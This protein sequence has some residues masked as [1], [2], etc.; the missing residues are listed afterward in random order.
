MVSKPSNLA[1]LFPVHK[2]S[3][4]EID[5]HLANGQDYLQDAAQ[6]AVSRAGRYKA[7]YDA[8][9]AFALAAIK[10][11]GFRPKEGGHRQSLFAALAHALPA[12][13]RDQ[14]VFEQ[15]HKERNRSEYDGAPIDITDSKLQALVAAAANLQEETLSL[16]KTWQTAQ[17]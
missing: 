8:S 4:A 12:T 2:A 9:H 10:M 13:E 17:N 16:Y 1:N 15:A 7:A 14:P 5:T 6:V 11:R 3:R